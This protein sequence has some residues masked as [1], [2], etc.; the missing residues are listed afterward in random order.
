M[1]ESICERRVKIRVSG[2]GHRRWA[3]TERDGWERD[4]EREELKMRS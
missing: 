3:V 4:R 1:R 2:S